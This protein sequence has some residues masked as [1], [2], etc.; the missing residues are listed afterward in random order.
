MH[1]RNVEKGDVDIDPFLGV[2][3]P[4]F[5]HFF[6]AVGRLTERVLIARKLLTEIGVY[7]FILR[8]PVL[9]E[10]NELTVLVRSVIRCQTRQ[11]GKHKTGL[12]IRMKVVEDLLGCNNVVVA[13]FRDFLPTLL[14]NILVPGEPEFLVMQPK[15]DLP[16]LER[17]LCGC[18]VVHIGVGQVV[19]L[20]KASSDA[21]L[22]D[23]L[24]QVVQLGVIEPQ[25]TSV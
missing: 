17:H 9:P 25:C 8:I 5:A 14:R 21:I 7:E 23:S 16:L 20:E 3:V 4:A 10:D 13:V 12:P 18:E 6:A 22:N 24:A 2:D 15:L 19:C 11:L 1:A